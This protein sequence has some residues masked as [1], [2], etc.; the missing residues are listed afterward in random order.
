[1]NCFNGT[2]H[3][4]HA[5]ETNMHGK[6]CILRG[7]GGPCCFLSFKSVMISSTE[8]LM[9]S[10]L[11]AKASSLYKS[12]GLTV[13]L[14]DFTNC[15]YRYTSPNRNS[16]AWFGKFHKVSHA[17]VCLR[18]CPRCFLFSHCIISAD[19]WSCAR[20]ARVSPQAGDSAHAQANSTWASSEVKRLFKPRI[21]IGVHEGCTNKCA[22]WC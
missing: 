9:K 2:T 3:A 10:N 4:K 5:T 12:M 13:S 8:I 1:M 18:V 14:S 16:Q 6:A 11:K 19:A 15:D 20:A 22:E 7:G 17:T 21:G